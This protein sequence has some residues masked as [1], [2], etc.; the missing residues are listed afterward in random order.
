[1]KDLNQEMKRTNIDPLQTVDTMKE[2]LSEKVTYITPKGLEKLKNELGYLRILKRREIANNLQETLGDIEDNEYLIALEE[3][4]FVEG[5]I[6][7]LEQ[8]LCN[9]KV[10]EPGKS[11]NGAVDLGST[12]VLREGDADAETY[13]IV[14]A[15][16]ADPKI[17]MISNESPLG[18]AL[19]G[20]KVGDDVE[21]KAPAGLLK[22]RVL[23]VQ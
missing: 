10:I 14:G 11:S 16:E 18:K 7:K 22:F 8:L 21:I 5:R 20:S 12:V 13:T 4:A 2:N 19:L 3:Q 9:V 6:R 23:A 17:G 15:A 1:M